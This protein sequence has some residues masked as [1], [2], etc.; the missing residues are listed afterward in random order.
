MK[1]YDYFV[2]SLTN[3]NYSVMDLKDAGLTT[4]NTQLKKI[5]DYRKLDVVQQAFTDENGV[6]KE[7]L[8]K[9]AY[10][11]ARMAYNELDAYTT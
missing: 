7:D 8:F 2:T 1:E 3:P 10:K 9:E 6:F 5:D 11:N 4:D